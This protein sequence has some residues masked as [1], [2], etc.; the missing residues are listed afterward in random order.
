MSGGGRPRPKTGGWCGRTER[1]EGATVPRFSPEGLGLDGTGA[2]GPK[3]GVQPQA[4]RQAANAAPTAHGIATTW[5]RS[6]SSGVPSAPRVKPATAI[7]R[8]DQFLA[9]T[10]DTTFLAGRNQKSL[11]ILAKQ[12][13]NFIL[14]TLPE[15]RKLLLGDSSVPWQCWPVADLSKWTVRLSKYPVLGHPGCERASLLRSEHGWA[16]AEPTAKRPSALHLS[17]GAREPVENWQTNGWHCFKPIQDSFRR[18]AA[19][20]GQNASASLGTGLKNVIENRELRRQM[21]TERRRPVQRNFPDVTGFG[22]QAVKELKFL[23]SLMSKLRMQPKRCSDP[24]P[25]ERLCDVPS[26]RCGSH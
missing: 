5:W 4:A 7:G 10:W 6:G 21:R 14:V 9:N 3:K 12:R 19:M 15:A 18:T 11:Q 13:S 8:M 26:L 16:Y 20:N 25:F 22:K 24:R 23:P 2:A 17:D 1:S